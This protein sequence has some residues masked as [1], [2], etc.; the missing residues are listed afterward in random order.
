MIVIWI[1]LCFV[2]TLAISIA[3]IMILGALAHV[4]DLK[5]VRMN[6]KL[7]AFHKDFPDSEIQKLQK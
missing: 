6:G 2:A 7:V 3:I 4:R 5:I 1:G